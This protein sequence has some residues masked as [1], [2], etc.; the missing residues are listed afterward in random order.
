MGE[1]QKLLDAF[2]RRFGGA[3]ISPPLLN[4]GILK[5]LPD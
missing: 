2:V 1:Q 5:Y 4:Q 3:E